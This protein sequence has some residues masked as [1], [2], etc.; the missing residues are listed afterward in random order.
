MSHTIRRKT[1]LLN[2]VRRI[3]GQVDAI[4]RALEAEAGCEQVMHVIAACRGAL[5]G[6]LG[7]VVEEHIQ[8]HLVEPLKDKDASAA[9]AAEQLKDVFRGYFR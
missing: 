6:L 7:E 5:N 4:E 2:R 3:R 8:S 1:K 9:E